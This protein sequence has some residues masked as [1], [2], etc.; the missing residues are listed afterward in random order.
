MESEIPLIDATREVRDL[1][2]TSQNLAAVEVAHGAL[3]GIDAL[4]AREIELG[5]LYALASARSGAPGAAARMIERLRA[6]NP[7]DRAISAD[8]ESLAGRVAKDAF[9]GLAVRSRSIILAAAPGAPE[10]ALAS[11]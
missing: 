10:R 11:A 8:I 4:G 5:Y 3:R 1:L 9:V 2:A 7:T 6:A